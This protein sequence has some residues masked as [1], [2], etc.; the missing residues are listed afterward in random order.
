[1]R[2]DYYSCAKARKRQ[3]MHLRHSPSKG[4][5]HVKTSHRVM[6]KAYTSAAFDTLPS[7][8]ISG[9][10]CLWVCSSTQGGHY[11]A[12]YISWWGTL[13]RM[14]ERIRLQVAG[15]C[16][17]ARQQSMNQTATSITDPKVL[18]HSILRHN[19][20][21]WRIHKIIGTKRAPSPWHMREKCF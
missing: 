17:G 9:A 16:F 10:M 3:I 13:W 7:S 8:N 6:P 1:M 11:V 4:W 14:R 12:Q 2:H 19:F 5:P 18:P 15:T 21:W 20:P